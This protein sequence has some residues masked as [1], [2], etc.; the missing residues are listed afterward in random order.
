[1]ICDLLINSKWSG[2]YSFKYGFMCIIFLFNQV[3][4]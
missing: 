3:Q 4:N 2:L 1:M